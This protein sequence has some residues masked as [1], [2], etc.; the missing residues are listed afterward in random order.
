[1]RSRLRVQNFRCIKVRFDRGPPF[2][3]LRMLPFSTS[4]TILQLCGCTFQN[5]RAMVDVVWACPNLAMLKILHAEFKVQPSS[6]AG[7]RQMSAAVEHLRACQKLTTLD[8]DVY[9]LSASSHVPQFILRPF[10]M[11]S[12]Y[13]KS[14]A[15]P[16]RD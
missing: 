7:L 1:M 12:L 13:R 10:M 9:T 5:F 2:R 11:Y 6:A 8:L 4:I 15:P 16:V 14:G 3:L